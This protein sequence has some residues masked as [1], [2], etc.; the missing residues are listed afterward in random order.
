[1]RPLL[2]LAVAMG[3]LLAGPRGSA[4]A[5]Q[6]NEEQHLIAVLQSHASPREK[7][8]ACA[9]L[10][11]I[12]TDRSVPALAALLTDE[13]LSHSARYALES[14]RSAKAGWALTDALSRTTGLTKV[15]LI[16]SLGMRGDKRAVPELTK[17]LKDPDMHVAAAAATALGQISGPKALK[18]LQAAAADSSGAVHD[19]V[20]DACLRCGR[21][22]LADGSQSKALTVFE[23]VY[24]TEKK[25]G[26]RTAAYRGMILASGKKALP[27][28]AGAIT[29]KDG[30]IQIAAL[31][32]VRE[33]TAPG[34]A[35]AFTKMLPKV[36]PAVQVALIEGLS[37]RGDVS[38][39][40]A[41]ATM[42]SS[43]APEVRLAA[44]N[45]LGILGDASDV[46]LLAVSAASASGDE[47]DAARLALVDLHRGNPTETLLRLL[48]DA[49]PAV[50]AEFARALGGR[51]A[52]VAVPN[53]VDLA[54]QG[55]GPAAKAARQA[56]A[57]L[58]ED[59]QLGLMVQLVTEAKDQ[60]TRSDAADA[61]NSAC[62]QIQTRRGRVNIEPLAQALATGSTNTRV[63]LLSVCSSLTDPKVR[64]ALRAAVAASDPQVRAAGIRA[65][66]DTSDAELLPDVL[67]LA[68][69]APEPNFR[70]LAIRACV[71]L[72]TQEETIKLSVQER[73]APLKA[74]LATD[75]NADQKR[76]VIAGL[77]ETPNAEA[78]A[79]VE[80]MLADEAIQLEAAK[81]VTK[82]AGALPYVQAQVAVDALQKVLTATTNAE[83]RAAAETALNDI[84]AGADYITAWQVA[85][86]YRQEG[87]DYKDLFD[88]LFPAEVVN[89]QG[90]RWKAMPPG[91][92]TKRPWIMDLL[93]E[94][95]GE[96]C[97]AYARTWVHSDQPQPAQLE[98]GS[99][100]GIKVW[101]NRKVVHANNT[102]RGLEVG[103]DKVNVTLNAG[104]NAL[105]LK[106]TQLNGGWAFC[107]RF[108]KPDGTHLDGLQFSA[109]RP[110]RAAAS[111][112][113]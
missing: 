67:R 30:A 81:A 26:F 90:V 2:L 61:L 49:Q 70:T 101:L 1:M 102:F 13:D 65:L 22:L 12:G 14:M 60:A 68:C 36:E 73:L 80:P 113:R 47:Q 69:A 112:G 23:R 97:V 34:A 82:I 95:G 86:P 15:G 40:S 66:C 37:Q 6:T 8:A 42:V 110:E 20:V 72:A 100:D 32:L 83:A 56:L 74:I 4:R 57:M 7:D 9:R 106:V 87:K 51:S 88:I 96:Q 33:V 54:R 111:T 28:I 21:H 58:V 109:Q 108:R 3:V 39:A 11:H 59:P 76:L 29:G 44:I 62:H 27:L 94:L 107:A 105:L 63:A 85:G 53:L 43:P 84:Q 92:D 38:A 10:K 93:K 16:N 50:Q 64:A 25:D 46:P 91:P 17:L 71:R 48:T 55:T 35:E 78:C 41:I 5:V 89:A 98:L 103:S 77:A 79:L 24:Q 104:W 45:A 31:Q 18:A 99:D 52:K 19:A 75:L